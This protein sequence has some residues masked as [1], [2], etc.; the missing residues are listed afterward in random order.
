[1]CPWIGV[2]FAQF[3]EIAFGGAGDFLVDIDLGCGLDARVLER[4]PQGTAVA[5]A[6]DQHALRIRMG[7]QRRMHHHFVIHE[8][9]A[10]GQHNVAIDRH[11]VAE[12]FGGVNRN[13]LIRTLDLV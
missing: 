9:V 12:R 11:Q 1:L 13:A 2:G 8:I 4:F 3:R 6:D 5:A 10:A 7:E